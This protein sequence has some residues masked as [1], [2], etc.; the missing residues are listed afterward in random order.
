VVSSTSITAVTPAGTSGSASVVVTDT[1]G[2]NAANTLFTYDAAPTITSVSPNNGPTSGATS[3]TLTG[4]GFVTGATLTIGGASATS[5]V[6]VSS[7]SI[8][9]VTP[10]GTS[11]SQNVV[12][13]DTAGSVTDTGAF[14][15]GA[16]TI[17]SVS[18][19]NAPP[20]ST[21]PSS[22]YGTPSSAPVSATG[23]TTVTLTS[24]GAKVVA[25]APAGALPGCTTLSIYPVTDPSSL[26]AQIPSGKSYLI[27]FG[28]S[29]QTCAGTSPLATSPL[30][31]TITDPSI[32]AGDVIY[33]LTST[34]LVAVGTASSNGTATVT[35]SN[36]PVFVWTVAS[37]A[38]TLTT[39][40]GRVGAPL[41]L[42]TRGGSGAGAVSFTVKNGTA[43]GCVISGSSLSATSAGTCLVTA[44]KAADATHRAVSSV[45]EV[46]FRVVLRAIKMTTAVW[47][48]KSTV[49]A[50]LG[51]GFYAH[52][53]IT[54]NVRGTRIGVLHDNGT[55]LTIRVTVAKSTPRGVHTFAIVFAHG[56]IITVRYN[57]R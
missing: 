33:E 55:R 18:P 30:T 47:T 17:T 38:L 29:W 57:Q 23:S 25:T 16:P 49:T 45:T 13:T 35:F 1:A 37:I 50:V 2:S 9:A 27:A 54:S 48:G 15:Y 3:I 8:T 12:V 22:S 14:I 40:S 5:V 31:M 32:V 41:A 11:G 51:A 24:G 46:A 28:V 52:P 56:E 7:T 26:V 19:T 42:A 6:V 34:G 39:L 43:T 10:A 20:P 36:D 53:R 4:T 44:T 21:L